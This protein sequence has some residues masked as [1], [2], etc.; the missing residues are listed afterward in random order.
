[1][2]ISGVVSEMLLL[3]RR[4]TITSRG[5]IISLKRVSKKRR[6]ELKKN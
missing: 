1:V 3:R 6:G 2:P 4:K 5:F